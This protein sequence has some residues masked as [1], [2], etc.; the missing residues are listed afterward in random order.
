M[1]PDGRFVLVWNAVERPVAGAPGN[2]ITMVGTPFGARVKLTDGHF[3]RTSA[4]AIGPQ[5]EH[6]VAWPA[7][8][9]TV[10][11]TLF[12][13]GNVV[14]PFPV[15]SS[16]RIGTAPS[17][18]SVGAGGFVVVWQSGSAIF[19]RLIRGEEPPAAGAL[20]D[21]DGNGAIGAFTDGLLVVRY[22]LGFRGAPLTSGA[23]SPSCVRCDATSVAEYLAGLSPLLDAD[24]NLT[25]TPFT[26]GILI[27]RYLLGFTGPTLIY[28]ALSGDCTRCDPGEI[29]E[30]LATLL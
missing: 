21:I 6:F 2:R 9:G 30:Y 25:V 1:A 7:I 8:N 3:A 20:L 23:I 29:A 19:G 4:V 27:L 5:G 16:G 24:G 12:N 15:S 14:G 18:A 26:D 10:R 17:V 22:L 13:Q 11:G 28:G